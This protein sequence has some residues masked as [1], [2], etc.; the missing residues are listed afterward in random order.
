MS[1]PPSL[2]FPCLYEPAD[3]CSICSCALGWPAGCS[4]AGQA[5][6]CLALHEISI[7]LQHHWVGRDFT[8]PAV[9]WLP[10]PAQAAQV[11]RAPTAL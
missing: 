2:V 8:A 5:A 3:S 6:L 4:S 10:P 11:L 1:L 7:Q 9:G